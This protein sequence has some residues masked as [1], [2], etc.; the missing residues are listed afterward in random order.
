MKLGTNV[1]FI[2]F[3]SLAS[4][5]SS[6]RGIVLHSEPV[7]STLLGPNGYSWINPYLQDYLDRR[8]TIGGLPF[9]GMRSLAQP[10]LQVE[11]LIQ[12]QPW[13]DHP[14]GFYDGEH[15]R[16][17]SEFIIRTKVINGQLNK[18][19]LRSE[20]ATAVKHKW[21]KIVGELFRDG[22]NF[23]SFSE[24]YPDTFAFS[25]QPVYGLQIIET[26][27]ER[28]KISRFTGG[29]RVE[30]GY[31]SRLYGMVD[32]RD[33]TEAGNGPYSTRAALYE[34]NVP[35]AELK[36][37]AGTSY[38]ISESILQYYG[39][40]LAVS[41]GRGRHKWGPGYFG[42]LLL[43][44]Y[45]PPFDYARFDANFSRV[46]FTFLHGF[47]ESIAPA[48]TLYTNPDGRP[49]T[50]N[51]QKFLSAQR[52]EVSPRNNLLVAFSQ[53]VVYGDRGLQLGYLTP[54]NFLYSVQHSN[55]D[56]D[57]LLLSFDGKWRPTRGLKFYGE[58][59]LDDVL[60]SDLFQGTG[61]SKNAYTVGVH[62]IVPKPIWEKFDARIEYT[63][64]RPFVYSHFFE[65]NTYSHWTSPLGYTREP[66]SEFIN[67]RLGASFYPLY[68]SLGYERQNHGANTETENV[69]GSIYET[70]YEGNNENF[71]FLAGQFEHTDK[72]N[73]SARYE[74]LPNLNLLFEIDAVSKSRVP[75]RT[76]WKAGFGWNL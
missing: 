19:Y 4:T 36:G 68:L 72:I 27:D 64:I 32:F 52:I 70:N 12:L 30:A 42:G 53:A 62:G 57:N 17:R 15:G 2:L 34:D 9:F 56:K 45:A 16:Y 25:F 47:L 29:F 24:T 38:D 3:L 74:V 65:V 14:E 63:K 1:F 6:A 46:N 73:F 41:A 55:D 7:D 54:L 43:N 37:D 71:P 11:W 66:N 75:D 13:R 44:S 10:N 31:D 33:I 8:E 50:I 18:R 58:L 60:V 67:L 51:A 76:E 39:K 20:E 61:N 59:L 69:G 35:N 26:D 28:D 40:N 5:T 22:Q 21:P 49:R 23:Y 48:D